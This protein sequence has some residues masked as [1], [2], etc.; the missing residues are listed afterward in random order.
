MRHASR[1][2]NLQSTAF[3]LALWLTGTCASACARGLRHRDFLLPLPTVS[4]AQKQVPRALVAYLRVGSLPAG[5][6]ILVRAR[7]GELVGSATPYGAQARQKPG[8]YTVPI[9]QS[10]I[11]NNAVLLQVELIRKG[12]RSR[13]PTRAEIQSIRLAY[14]PVTQ[15]VPKK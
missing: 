6:R 8:I 15:S 12:L 5:A 14:I 1:R 3:A 11:Q 9:P 13:A 4:A 10:A 7:T 2:L